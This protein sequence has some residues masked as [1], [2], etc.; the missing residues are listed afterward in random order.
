MKITKEDY[1]R[2]QLHRDS[3]QLYEDACVLYEAEQNK[4]GP[5]DWFIYTHPSGETQI[6]NASDVWKHNNSTLE[7]FEN[8]YTVKLS[9]EAQDILN[10]E[11]GMGTKDI[12]Q[13][14]G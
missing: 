12:V 14:E 4:I 1:E 2:F 6:L 3:H 9:P 11:T 5:G 10:K 13:G 7:G 8:N